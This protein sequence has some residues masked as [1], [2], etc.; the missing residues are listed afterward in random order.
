MA[1]ASW[2]RGDVVAVREIWRGRV[3]K[4][5]PFV[6]VHDTPDQLALFIPAGSPTKIPPGSGIPREEW[7]LEDG[8]FRSDVLRLARPDEPHSVLLFWRDGVFS[9]WYVNFERPLTRSAVGFDYLDRELDLL[10]R[11]D[12][13]T[14]LLDEDE[15]EEAQRL[16]V[17]GPDEAAAVLAELE[18]V[19]DLVERWESP[20]ADGWERWRAD[21]DWP[22][23]GL[24]A[25]WDVVEAASESRDLG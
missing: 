2:S 22:V 17:I 16:G 25:G 15:F 23:P 1:T 18:R 8:V 20:F 5:R 11:P 24:P 14:E 10:V 21:P 7:T 3:W 4:A 6:V 12:R 9:G 13:T 19:R